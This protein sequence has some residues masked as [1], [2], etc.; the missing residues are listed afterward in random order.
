MIHF[1]NKILYPVGHTGEQELPTKMDKDLEQKMQQSTEYEPVDQVK[2][3]AG[4]G[5]SSTFGQKH[6]S[7]LRNK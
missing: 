5:T 6:Q 7:E 2:E 3:V 1:L 4:F